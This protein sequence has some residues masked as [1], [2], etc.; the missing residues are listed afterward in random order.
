[1]PIV[2]GMTATR[3]IR[4]Q[5]SNIAK[6]SVTIE[7]NQ[8][9]RIP[10]FAVSASIVAMNERAYMDAGFDGW[11]MKP[12]DFAR[13]NTILAGIHDPKARE[14]SGEARDWEKGGW[15]DLE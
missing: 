7:S 15:F 6:S 4:E 10:I 11:V 1:M 8:S 3:M 13:L 14:G 5:E 2:D 9:K 12:V